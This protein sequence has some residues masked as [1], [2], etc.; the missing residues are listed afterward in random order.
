MSEIEALRQEPL[1]SVVIPTYNYGHFV[2][3]AV[4]SVLAQTYKRREIIVVDDG[5]SDDTPERLAPYRDR[6]RYVRKQNRG[7][8][9]ARNTGIG[10]ASGE[11]VALLDADDVWHPQKLALQ[12]RVLREHPDLSCLGGNGTPDALQRDL[13][14]DPE[15]E[16]LSVVDFLTWSPLGVCAVIARRRCFD[17]VGGFDVNL[18]YAEDRD[19]WIR[20]AARYATARLKVPVFQY[21]P[22]SGQASRNALPMYEGLA[23]VLNRF[24]EQNPRFLHLRPAASAFLY[25]DATLAFMDQDDRL[26]ALSFLMRWLVTY[27]RTLPHPDRDRSWER[28]K[29]FARLLIG[30]PSE[31]HGGGAPG[32]ELMARRSGNAR[33]GVVNRQPDMAGTGDGRTEPTGTFE[34]QG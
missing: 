19:M 13:P 17:Q 7:V 29:V 28:A 14:E 22:H 31:H 25:R 16:R 9:A 8:S 6:I 12:M 32:P 11:W 20:L 26:T 1:V 2:V 24:F 21:R 15:V 5:S 10:L 34:L 18:R 30:S 4:E 33:E 3:D 27:P 23:L